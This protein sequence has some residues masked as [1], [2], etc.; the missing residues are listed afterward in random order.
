MSRESA[1]IAGD[2]LPEVHLPHS[3]VIEPTRPG[4][5]QRLEAEQQAIRDVETNAIDVEYVE[6]GRG[7]LPHDDVLDA[8]TQVRIEAASQRSVEAEAIGVVLVERARQGDDDAT[9]KKHPTSLP[10]PSEP[11]LAKELANAEADLRIAEAAHEYD[12]AVL[13]GSKVARDGTRRHGKPFAA[14]TTNFRRALFLSGLLALLPLI[15]PVLIEGAV[16][17]GNLRHYLRT[18]EWLLPL[19]MAAIVVIS[20]TV[21]PFFIGRA[22]NSV[23]HGGSLSRWQWTSLGVATVVWLAVGVQLA[24]LRVSVDRRTAVREAEKAFNED[25]TSI[26]PGAEQT[27]ESFDPSMVDFDVPTAVMVWI[28]ILV[29]IGAILILFE[30]LTYNPARHTELASRYA[31][32]QARRR[33]LEATGQLD[34][35]RGQVRLQERLAEASLDEWKIE[36]D[37]IRADTELDKRIYQIALMN[38]SGNPQMAMA[39]NVRYGAGQA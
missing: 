4:G 21:G 20:L 5:R 30:A 31:V 11:V 17:T 7:P 18:A 36:S 13:E 12:R 9:R 16:V 14:G 1:D 27:A 23:S 38:A 8:W 29:G 34:R 25:Q 37:R 19:S 15:A 10:I 33:V 32:H 2:E 26:L 24:R 22:I 3:P 28:S 6:A 39:L 35:V